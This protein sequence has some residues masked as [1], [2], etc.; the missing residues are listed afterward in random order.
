MERL[1]EAVQES[2]NQS[3][4]ALSP[5]LRFV[6]APSSAPIDELEGVVRQMRDIRN[7]IRQEVIAANRRIE[8]LL[9]GAQYE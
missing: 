2:S 9:T 5:L 8:E 3:Q 7:S 1:V 4:L 6:N